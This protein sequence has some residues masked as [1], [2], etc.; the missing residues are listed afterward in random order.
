MEHL[1]THKV[2]AL[3]FSPT[4]TTRKVVTAIAEGI[5]TGMQLGKPTAIN[6]TTPV[7]RRE[8]PA[9]AQGDIVVFGVPVYIGRVPNLIRDFFAS[10]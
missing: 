8:T 6:V 7:H 4:Y 5:A 9:F 3:F 2:A 1:N 10:I